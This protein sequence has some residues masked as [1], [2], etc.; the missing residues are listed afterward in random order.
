MRRTCA[1]AGY[2]RATHRKSSKIC[3]IGTLALTSNE[4]MKPIMR[5]RSTLTLETITQ[6]GSQMTHEINLSLTFLS[7]STFR[8]RTSNKIQK[9]TSPRRNKNK[10]STTSN[11]KAIKS[12]I[13][14]KVLALMKSKRNYIM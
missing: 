8:R 11:S 9:F 6:R 5:K 12:T 13:K 14:R 1:Q 4:V 7:P 3:A 10:Q 2:G